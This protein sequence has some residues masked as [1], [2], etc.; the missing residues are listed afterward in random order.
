MITKL[1]WCGVVLAAFLLVLDSLKRNRRKPDVSR[2]QNQPHVYADAS[3]EDIYCCDVCG[4]PSTDAIHNKP[5]R[6]TPSQ[7][8]NPGRYF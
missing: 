5:N 6:P 1:F 3:E 2:Y 8:Q 7:L 4:R